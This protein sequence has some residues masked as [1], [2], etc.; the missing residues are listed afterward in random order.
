MFALS[1]K[2]FPHTNTFFFCR[3]WAEFLNKTVNPFIF[4]DTSSCECWVFKLFEYSSIWRCP[5]IFCATRNDTFQNQGPFF[6]E[7]FR[8]PSVV[9]YFSQ[10]DYLAWMVCSLC[11]LCRIHQYWLGENLSNA[12]KHIF[13]HR[14]TCMLTN[15]TQNKVIINSYKIIL[16][17]S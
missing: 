3:N 5:E 2:V 11:T 6:D 17:G 10:S 1:A 16:A 8:G 14:S 9:H 4:T 12:Y 7:K 15:C 13:T